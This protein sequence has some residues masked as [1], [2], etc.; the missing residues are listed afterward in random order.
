[1]LP[2]RAQQVGAATDFE[3]ITWLVIMP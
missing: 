2:D 1:V 3:L